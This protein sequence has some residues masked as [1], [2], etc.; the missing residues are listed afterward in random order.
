[1]LD[2]NVPLPAE[3]FVNR[4]LQTGVAIKR[5]VSVMSGLVLYTVRLDD[6]GHSEELFFAVSL[7]PISEYPIS[8][9]M[10]VH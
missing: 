10:E 8:A 7:S 4:T 5:E 1:M 2:R 3:V 9:V 6:I